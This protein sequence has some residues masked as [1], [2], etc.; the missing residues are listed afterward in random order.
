[1]GELDAGLE[2]DVAKLG[3]V[4][5]RRSVVDWV[6]RCRREGRGRFRVCFRNLVFG[7]NFLRFTCFCGGVGPFS[8]DE[9]LPQP[10]R[11]T[12]DSRTRP[13]LTRIG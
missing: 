13:S 5:R 3:V 8:S 12:A 4:V 6:L 9:S 2:S 10:A 7:R 11:R 1:M